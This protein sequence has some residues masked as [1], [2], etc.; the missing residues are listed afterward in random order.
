MG[1]FRLMGAQPS[2]GSAALTDNRPEDQGGNGQGQHQQLQIRRSNRAFR[3][4]HGCDLQR[5]KGRC[6]P[7]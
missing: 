4:L 6:E 5:Q 1:Q 7:E 3:S 2:I